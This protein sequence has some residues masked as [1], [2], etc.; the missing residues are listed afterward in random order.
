M[1]H[2]GVR[3]KAG[4]KLQGYRMSYQKAISVSVIESSLMD[5]DICIFPGI[6]KPATALWSMD[7]ASHVISTGILAGMG[8]LNSRFVST[9]M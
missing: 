3:W 5:H 7:H 1:D 2:Y 8:I 9:W 4:F 6:R